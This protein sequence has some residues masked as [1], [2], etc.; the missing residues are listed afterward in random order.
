MAKG[1]NEKSV[2]QTVAWKDLYF[3]IGCGMVKDGV[4]PN[5]PVVQRPDGTYT[6]VTIYYLHLNFSSYQ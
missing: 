3:P 1:A 4:K 2:G 6:S 5:I